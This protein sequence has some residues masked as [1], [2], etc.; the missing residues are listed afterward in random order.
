MVQQ[1]CNQIEKIATQHLLDALMRPHEGI[2]TCIFNWELFL[3]GVI[4]VSFVIFILW[5]IGYRIF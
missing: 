4:A 5:E 2:G 3:V 1:L